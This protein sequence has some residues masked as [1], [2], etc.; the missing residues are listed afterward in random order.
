[1][2]KYVVAAAFV[3]LAWASAPA[4]AADAIVVNFTMKADQQ[5]LR[6]P[7]RQDLFN[8]GLTDSKVESALTIKCQA[9]HTGWIKRTDEACSVT[10]NGVVLGGGKNRVRGMRG[11]H[12]PV[13]IG[14]A[15]ASEILLSRRVCNYLTPVMV[16]SCVNLTFVRSLP[17]R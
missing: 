10:G 17:G 5:S 3:A 6:D 7:T 4:V 9:G 1:M 12:A 8:V 13:E 15:A 2:K 11:T 16:S 14:C